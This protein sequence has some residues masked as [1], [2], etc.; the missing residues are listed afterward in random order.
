MDANYHTH[1]YRCGHARGSDEQF[2]RAAIDGGFSILGFSDHVPYIG[3]HKPSDRMD[4]EQIDEYLGSIAA[5]KAKYADQ[6]EIKVAFEIEFF[7]ELLDYYKSLREKVDYLI[8]GQHNIYNLDDDLDSYANDHDVKA[9]ADHVVMA[10]ESGVIDYL[11]HP[12]YFM[13]GR[14]HWSKA[15]AEAAHRISA[16]CAKAKTPMELNLNGIRYGHLNFKDGKAYVYPYRSFWEIVAQYDTICVYGYDAHH[17][18]TL[19]EHN[20]LD[21]INEIIKGIPL[22]IIENFRF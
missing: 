13:L 6:I 7:P 17:P 15:C 4:F 9:Y 2:V 10:V 5:L 11:A 1:T 22:H 14:R 21:T 19:L 12:D 16:A 8:C 18:T 3:I 20:R